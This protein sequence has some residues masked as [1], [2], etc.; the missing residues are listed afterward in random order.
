MS[1]QAWVAVATLAF[2]MFVQFG[3]AIWW[4]SS[5]SQR[6]KSLEDKAKDQGNTRDE[7]IR[8]QEQIK[9]LTASINTLSSQQRTTRQR[10]GQS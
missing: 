2:F 10:Q 7:V 1:D 6:M 9:A 4:A 5:I 8:L 3:V